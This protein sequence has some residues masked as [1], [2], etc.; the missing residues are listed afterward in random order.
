MLPLQEIKISLSES[1]CTPSKAEKRLLSLIKQFPDPPPT[2]PTPFNFN[3]TVLKSNTLCSPVAHRYEKKS[4]SKES[5]VSSSSLKLLN[6]LEV[7][8][9]FTKA[10]VASEWILFTPRMS[11]WKN[12]CIQCWNCWSFIQKLHFAQIGRCHFGYRWTIAF[13]HKLTMT[14]WNLWQY[15]NGVFLPAN[16]GLSAITQRP[17]KNP[18]LL[19]IFFF[20]GP[21]QLLSLSFLSHLRPHCFLLW[22]V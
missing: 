8:T 15:Q 13:L 17:P 18:L 22:K 12:L 16:N 7:N 9:C 1:L 10:I 14:I 3:Y 20:L 5:A 19:S 6:F 4:N 21:L 11:G 2:S